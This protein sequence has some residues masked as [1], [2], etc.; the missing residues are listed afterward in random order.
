[1]PKHKFYKYFNSVDAYE[2]ALDYTIIME[3]VLDI[4]FLFK[5]SILFLDT[6]FIQWLNF[7]YLFGCLT[8]RYW[9]SQTHSLLQKF[10]T[11]NG[12][13]CQLIN[14]LI[15]FQANNNEVKMGWKHCSHHYYSPLAICHFR[16][17]CVIQ[18]KCINSYF[19]LG[20][21]LNE[22][23]RI[24]IFEKQY[25]TCSDWLMIP[26]ALTAVSELLPWK[27]INTMKSDLNSVAFD[28]FIVE[29]V[30]LGRLLV[31]GLS[32]VTC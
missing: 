21:R 2:F 28:T 30:L 11:E 31:V 24:A 15:I 26:L 14:I 20:E 16:W 7:M 12:L 6:V 3:L 5:F 23:Q 29:Y 17:I 27:W 25:R 10:I 22:C 32:H 4:F 13:E 8:Q 1:M 9:V 18:S 19:F